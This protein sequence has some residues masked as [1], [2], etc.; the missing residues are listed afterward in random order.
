MSVGLVFSGGGSC[1]AYQIG[2]WKALEEFGREK[3]ITAVSGSSVGAL[4]ALL[5]ANADPDL[6][7][8][9][10]KNLR[11]T[12]FFYPRG[13]LDRKGW[14]SQIGF[15]KMID[16]L[17]EKWPDLRKGMP[18]YSCVSVL[19]NAQGGLEKIDLKLREAGSP[20][21][22]LLNDLE[23]NA[24]KNVL[25]ASTAIPYIYPHR[26]IKGKTCIDGDFSD[27]TP[28]RPLADAGCRNIM[29]LHLNTEEE[30]G[31]RRKE[32]D[33]ANDPKSGARLFHLYPSE[34]LGNFLVVT[35][36]KTERRMLMG[37]ED[38]KYFLRET[39]DL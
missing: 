29:I 6:A 39:G 23:Y 30:A 15:A 11:Q 1:G 32:S 4:N 19:N 28:Y 38:G 34:T 12:D 31:R 10:W 37:Y 5:F 16:V 21:Y 7:E 22:I 25:L 3:K 14:F 36:K 20:Q 24:M 26:H 8:E 33:E 13:F 35:R 17:K 9:I 2:F 27:K 18:I